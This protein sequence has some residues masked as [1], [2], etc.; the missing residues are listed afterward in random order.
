M[1]V[2]IHCA[3]KGT[4]KLGPVCHAGGETGQEGIDGPVNAGLTHP[5]DRALQKACLERYRRASA[6]IMAVIRTIVPQVSCSGNFVRD[7]NYG[8][9]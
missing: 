9:G 5:N 1:T 2:I 3:F 6:E 4:Y 8:D 7:Q